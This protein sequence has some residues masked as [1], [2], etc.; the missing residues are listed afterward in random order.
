M[1]TSHMLQVPFLDG[2]R[3]KVME[4]QHADELAANI[5]QSYGGSPANIAE[6]MPQQTQRM[7]MRIKF[8]KGLPH[9]APFSWKTQ[10]KTNNMF[11]QDFLKNEN[12]AKHRKTFQRNKRGIPAK[13]NA[14]TM[15]HV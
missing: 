4:P 15:I 6:A 5:V 3:C 11:L 7:Y 2:Q 10:N 13:K 1:M 8:A 12:K 9:T 14:K